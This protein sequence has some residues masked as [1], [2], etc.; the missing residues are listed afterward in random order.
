MTKRAVTLL[1]VSVVLVAGAA[2]VI[3][4]S[5]GGSDM[6][7]S[8]HVMSNGQTMTGSGMDMGK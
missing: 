5:I 4:S 3:A 6:H 1:I 7:S 2:A 8:R